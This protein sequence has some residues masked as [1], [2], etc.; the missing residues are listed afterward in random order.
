MSSVICSGSTVTLKNRI[1]THTQRIMMYSVQN[2]KIPFKEKYITKPF[3]MEHSFCRLTP[4]FSIINQ[5]NI[6]KNEDNS[7]CFA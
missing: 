5:D 6:L 7:E 1:H 3:F 2:C 4:Q